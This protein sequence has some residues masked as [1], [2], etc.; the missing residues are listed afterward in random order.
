MSGGTLDYLYIHIHWIWLFIEMMNLATGSGFS[1]NPDNLLGDSEM[2]HEKTISRFLHD[3]EWVLS[4]NYPKGE[5]KEAVEN[6]PKTFLTNLLETLRNAPREAFT[7]AFD[8][9]PFAIG[10]MKI[11]PNDMLYA[12]NEGVKKMQQYGLQGIEYMT[13]IRDIINIIIENGPCEIS[14]DDVNMV[15][16]YTNTSRKHAVKVLRRHEGDPDIAIKVIDDED[17]YDETNNEKD[18]DKFGW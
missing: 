4:G 8:E 7:K 5:E 10:L 13:A 6:M 1:Y 11:N 18:A 15:I 9:L 17:P 14:D 16:Y 3:V 2:E 12:S